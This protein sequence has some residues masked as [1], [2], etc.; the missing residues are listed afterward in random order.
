MFAT[1]R[2][3]Q[4]VLA[5]LS[6]ELVIVVL[7]VTMALWADSWVAD[8]SDREEESARLYALQDN[9]AETLEDLREERNNAAGAVDALRRLTLRP[10]LPAEELRMLLRFAFLYG[11]TFSPELDVYDDLKNSG[12][13]A[14]LTN[15]ELRQALASMDTRLEVLTLAQS[16]LASVQQLE[17]DSYALDRTNMRILYGDDIG[18]DWVEVDGQQ[19]FEF[20]SDFRFRNRILFKLDLVTVLVSSFDDAENALTRAQQAIVTQLATEQ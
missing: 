12:E 16:D 2:K 15:R 9:I 18:I 7:G 4:K 20:M 19:D 1:R 8:R 10:D 6:A 11:P 3:W 14:L 17:I 5:R 13:L